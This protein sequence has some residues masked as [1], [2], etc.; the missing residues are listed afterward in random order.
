MG[1]S[2]LPSNTWFPGP[3]QVPNPN[4]MSTGSLQPF[5]QI[6]L[7]ALCDFYFCAI[8]IHWYDGTAVFETVPSAAHL[9]WHSRTFGWLRHT[10][11]GPQSERSQ[12][13]RFRGTFYTRNFQCTG[14]M[15]RKQDQNRI[16][17]TFT[18]LSYRLCVRMRVT[19][20][21][22]VVRRLKGWF[23][24]RSLPQRTV[25]CIRCESGSTDGKEDGRRRPELD[26]EIFGSRCATAGQSSNGWALVLLT[27]V[28]WE[29][30]T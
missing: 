3:T 4:G 7:S 14:S 18:H 29:A 2:G 27:L 24:T 11:G 20:V 6:S 13:V 9:Y 1:E 23:L 22:C 26:L 12:Y 19:L 16:P 17:R 21:Y 5:L 28:D 10:Y 25:N 8:Q 15:P 30:A